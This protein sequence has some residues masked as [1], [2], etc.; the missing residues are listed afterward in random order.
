MPFFAQPPDL[1]VRSGHKIPRCQRAISGRMP[2]RRQQRMG[3]SQI[4]LT[5][6]RLAVGTDRTAATAHSGLYSC[7]PDMALFTDPP[8][9]LMAAGKDLI[10]PQRSVFCWMP[11]CNQL[12]MTVC[13]VIFSWNGTPA[14]AIGASAF[15]AGARRHRGLP[16]VAILAAPPHFLFASIGNLLRRQVPVLYRVLLP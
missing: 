7:A 12:R 14:H 10:R 5:G 4:I 9:P 6:C 3:R 16:P 1:F 11:L 2:L 15:I 13:Q 8:G